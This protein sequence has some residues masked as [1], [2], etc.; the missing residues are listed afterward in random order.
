MACWLSSQEMQDFLKNPP[1]GMPAVPEDE[2]AEIPGYCKQRDEVI[3]AWF[4]NLVKALKDRGLEP[5]E[6]EYA[7]SQGT[8]SVR[9]G[10]EK[11]SSIT[12]E[13]K[14]KGGTVVQVR[15]DDGLKLKDQWR[16]TDK[17]LETSVDGQHLDVRKTKAQD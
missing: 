6:L 3:A 5:Q 4:P 17:P 1:P 8:V 2:A 10:V 9:Y 15:I 7:G 14:H 13:F 11:T 12:M 16:F